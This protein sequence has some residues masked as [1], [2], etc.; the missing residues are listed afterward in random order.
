MDSACLLQ[1]RREVLIRHAGECY[2]LRHT[3][4]G[5]LILTK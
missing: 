4:N 5:K 1:G 2:R 3:R